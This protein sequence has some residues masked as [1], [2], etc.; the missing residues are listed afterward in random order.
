MTRAVTCDVTNTL[1]FQKNQ[2]P[3]I[4]GPIVGLVIVSVQA[5]PVPRLCVGDGSDIR[6]LFGL[7]SLNPDYNSKVQTTQGKPNEPGRDR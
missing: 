2:I 7:D 4:P 5:V 6:D 3:F 1:P